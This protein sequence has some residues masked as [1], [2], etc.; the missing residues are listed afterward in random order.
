[1]KKILIIDEKQ[2][3]RETYLSRNSQK[4]KL[5]KENDRIEIREN[6]DCRAFLDLLKEPDKLKPT[7]NDYV[8]IACHH[9]YIETLEDKLKQCCKDTHIP[10]ILFSGRYQTSYLNGT[11]L[12]T[13]VDNFYLQI[14]ETAYADVINDK[15]VHLL[16]AAF[17]EQYELSVLL[18]IREKL[19]EWRENRDEETTYSDLSLPNEALDWVL[20]TS[21][22]ESCRK[23]QPYN[24]ALLQQQNEDLSKLIASKL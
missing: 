1:M 15:E 16:K 19:Y 8:L 24:A 14:L 4:E 17:G 11:V 5:F 9:S 23:D 12:Q 10:L 20:H 18:D 2:K 22:P 3:R 13:S 21:I 6:A 7:L